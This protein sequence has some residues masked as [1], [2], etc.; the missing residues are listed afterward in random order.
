MPQHIMMYCQHLLGVG[1]LYR[2]ARIAAACLQSGFKVT[3]VAGGERTSQS[4]FTGCDWVQLPPIK[5][6]DASF[7]EL[8]TVDGQPVSASYWQQ[9]QQVLMDTIKKTSPDVFL[10]EMYPFGRRA[11]RHELTPILAALKA[12]GACKIMC[13][14]RDILVD[15][16]VREPQRQ[17]WVIH[18]LEQYF[19]A[20]LVH[21]D[22]QFIRLQDT[23]P[24]A[25]RITSLLYYT[26]YVGPELDTL[27]PEIATL[28]SAEPRQ[29]V[30][31]S[32]G[33]S[34]VAE[35]MMMALLAARPYSTV[36]HW[37][38]RFLLGPRSSNRLRQALSAANK[39]MALGGIKVEGLRDDFVSLLASA[40]LSIS[41]AGYN[42]VMDVLVAQCPALLL[43]FA[44][45]EETEQLFRA[46]RLSAIGCCY[47]VQAEQLSPQA[48]AEC[49]DK[50]V[51]LNPKVSPSPIT[52]GGQ[53]QTVNIIKRWLNDESA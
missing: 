19:D 15:K 36:A 42:T 3:I 38:W 26:G 17:D 11:F 22:E 4:L 48:L 40:G 32:A 47:Y 6:P 20:V 2:L 50:A 25:A 7:S 34:A 10:V 43:P 12:Q 41:Q 44:N 16:F 9:R 1:H 52:L 45:T 39:D 37:T 49:I 31:V 27:T 30:V 51:S 35:Q 46:Q 5:V 23:F 29:E 53:W 33:S 24:A 14:L 8:V 21:G 28:T 18:Q 13:S